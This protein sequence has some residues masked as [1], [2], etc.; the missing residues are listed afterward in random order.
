MVGF[1]RASVD[2]RMHL[3][4]CQDSQEQITILKNFPMSF[5]SETNPLTTTDTFFCP[6]SF[7]S[8]EYTKGFIYNVAF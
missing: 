3:P 5:C 8:Q 6:Y 4:N 7:T 1:A 2:T